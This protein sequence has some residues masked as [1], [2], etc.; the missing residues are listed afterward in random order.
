M[1][2]YNKNKP[3]DLYS[4]SKSEKNRQWVENE[5][6]ER[7]QFFDF[8]NYEGMYEGYDENPPAKSEARIKQAILKYGKDYR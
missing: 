4:L 6:S 5:K 3:L 8:I 2:E 1:S 7:R